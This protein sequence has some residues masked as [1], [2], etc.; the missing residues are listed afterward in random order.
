M[1]PALAGIVQDSPIHCDRTRLTRKLSNGNY[2]L[3]PVNAKEEF[4]SESTVTSNARRV[5]DPSSPLRKKP[6]RTI[7]NR[8]NIRCKQD[9]QRRFNANIIHPHAFAICLQEKTR[10]STHDWQTS[11]STTVY[12]GSRLIFFTTK[13]S[14]TSPRTCTHNF[15]SI[16]RLEGRVVKNPHPLEYHLKSLC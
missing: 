15:C 3:L 8:K 12:S 10:S 9:S 16:V 1:S 14:T 4:F 13:Y 11:H 6:S 7:H 5:S 2:A